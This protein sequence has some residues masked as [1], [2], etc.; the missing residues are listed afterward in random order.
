MNSLA[1]A[2]R[3]NSTEAER[4]LWS[5][6]R[7]RRLEGVKFRR[8]QVPLDLRSWISSAWSPK[9]SSRSMVASMPSRSRTTCRGLN[10]SRYWVIA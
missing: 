7:G 9:L 4:C 3:K 2:L 5:R 8:Q 10:I 6:L 1:R